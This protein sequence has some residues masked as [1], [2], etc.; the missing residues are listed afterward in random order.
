VPPAAI[1]FSKEEEERRMQPVTATRGVAS[2]AAIF[3]DLDGTLC[4]PIV[5]F[6]D[7]FGTVAAPLLQRHP[8]LAL[9]EVLRRWSEALLQPGPSTTAGCFRQ[10]LATC[11]LAPA[12]EIITELADELNARWAASQ[13]LASAARSVLATLAA[14][15]PLGLITNGP[16]DAQRAVVDALGITPLFRW[17]LVSGDTDIGS[18]KPAPTIFARAAHLAGCPPSAMLYVGDSAANDVAGAAMAGW[19]VCWLNRFADAGAIGMPRPDLEIG[20]LADLPEAIAN[21]GHSHINGLQ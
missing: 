16:S 1:G 5:P 4:T 7:V 15:W 6:T 18:R 20:R 3:F 13:A 8:D 2:L 10:A 21:G 19:R 17:L 9:A 14:T 12:E 11:A